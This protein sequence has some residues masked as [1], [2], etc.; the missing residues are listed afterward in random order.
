MKEMNCKTSDELSNICEFQGCNQCLRYFLVKALMALA[1]SLLV[2]YTVGSNM[3]LP[4][5]FN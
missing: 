4:C 1:L 2:V 3:S 5:E